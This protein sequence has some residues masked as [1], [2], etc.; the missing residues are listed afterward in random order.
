MVITR[1]RAHAEANNLN[2]HA[3]YEQEAIGRGYAHAN[4]KSMPGR[5]RP[6]ALAAGAP[7]NSSRDHW[8]ANLITGNLLRTPRLCQKGLCVFAAPQALIIVQ[9]Y[10]RLHDRRS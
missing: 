2:S 6:V 8:L 5:N 7:S 3:G 10:H 4:T 9:S 1:I